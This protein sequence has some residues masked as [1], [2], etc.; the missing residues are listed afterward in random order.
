VHVLRW[1]IPRL[2]TVD[3]DDLAARAAE[4]ERPA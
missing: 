2:A 3:D 1:K 4:N